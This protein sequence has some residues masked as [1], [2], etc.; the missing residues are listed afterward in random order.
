MAEGLI[1]KENRRLVRRELIYYLKAADRKTGEEIGRLGDIHTEGMLL[2]TYEPLPGE[3]VF[4]VSLELPKAMA[5][6]EGYAEIPVRAQ[7]LWSKPG[8]KMSNYY[9]NGLSFLNPPAHLKKA[10][11]RLMDVF[12]M[13]HN[14]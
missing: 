2:L 8:P 1:L 4:E 13:P 11:T 9:E 12:A 7:S 10:I 3:T 5:Q 14:M 6:A